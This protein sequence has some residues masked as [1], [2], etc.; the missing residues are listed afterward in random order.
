[1]TE[2]VVV[3]YFKVQVTRRSRRSRTYLIVAGN[4]AGLRSG[5]FMGTSYIAT[6]TNLPGVLTLD[7]LLSEISLLYRFG[8]IFFRHCL[9]GRQLILT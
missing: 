9:E 4:P 7:P 8:V 6:Y 5:Y 3:T 1:M 2:E